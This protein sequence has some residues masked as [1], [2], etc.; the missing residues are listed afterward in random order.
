MIV[1]IK[2]DAILGAIKSHLNTIAQK[3]A[4]KI[5]SSLDIKKMANERMANTF[6]KECKNILS[7]G[8]F[9]DALA[10]RVAVEISSSLMSSIDINK[11]MEYAGKEIAKK[12]SNVK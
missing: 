5:A 1:E 8:R 9:Y 3:E 7:D 6:D 12:M 11:V 10:K 4:N 2:D